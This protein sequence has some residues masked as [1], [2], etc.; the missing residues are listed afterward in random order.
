M[1]PIDS[2]LIVNECNYWHYSSVDKYRQAISTLLLQ[3]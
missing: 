1:V 3:F 2:C